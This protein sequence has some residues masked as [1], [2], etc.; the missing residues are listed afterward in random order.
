MSVDFFW[1]RVDWKA[2]DDLSPKQL[3]ALVPGWFDDDFGPQRDAGVV[4]AVERNGY[5]M[6]VALT[7]AVGG[8]GPEVAAVRLPLFGGEERVVVEGDPDR[9]DEFTETSVWVL[10]PEEVRA[11]SAFLESVG[12]G[13]LVG[14]VEATL[15]SEVAGLGFVA[16]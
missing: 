4:L 8:S 14:R 7:A 1:R 11:A 6:D 9:G 13:D 5:L 16:P 3:R 2:L 15:A 12:V 10:R